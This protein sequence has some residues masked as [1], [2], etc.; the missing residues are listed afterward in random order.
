MH[1]TYLYLIFSG[2]MLDYCGTRSVC[3]YTDE[4]KKKRL[5]TQMKPKSTL[6]ILKKTNGILVT[7]NVKTNLFAI[8]TFLYETR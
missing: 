4:L 5:T 8:Y 6:N 2:I 1:F 3:R 7:Y